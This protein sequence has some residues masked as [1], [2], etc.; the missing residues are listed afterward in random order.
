MVALKVAMQQI[1]GLRYKI[2]RMGLPIDGPANVF[3]DNAAVANR[4]SRPES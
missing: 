3:H 1:K 2:L 4:A